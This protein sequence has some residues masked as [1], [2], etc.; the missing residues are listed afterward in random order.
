M[1]LFLL[2]LLLQPSPFGYL[3]AQLGA[4]S[5]ALPRIPAAS[6]S[7]LSIELEHD[8]VLWASKVPGGGG[9]KR[10]S[11]AGGA[12][13][14]VHIISAALDD[15]TRFALSASDF[16]GGG[17][18]SYLHIRVLGWSGRRD[19]HKVVLAE[20]VAAIPQLQ[21]TP[22]AP[23]TTQ[24]WCTLRSPAGEDV[25][26]L[27]LALAARLPAGSHTFQ[28]S[29]Q[30]E[31][32]AKDSKKASKSNQPAETYVVYSAGEE[33]HLAVPEHADPQLQL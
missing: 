8:G 10:M 28:A 26:R 5:L 16:V 12:N 22:A 23:S 33:K 2:P 15:H 13:S 9:C 32:P 29:A 4:L 31:T 19:D 1:V 25:G 3:D 7:H 18:S 6:P 20:G 11:P 24:L 21:A 17:V 27:Q 30:P 14:S